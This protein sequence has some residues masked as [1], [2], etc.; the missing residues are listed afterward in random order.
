MERVEG[1][2]QG[3]L[4]R[5]ITKGP[6]RSHADRGLKFG[7]CKEVFAPNGNLNELFL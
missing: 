1:L 7:E 6:G 5:E 3:F 2:N 4:Q